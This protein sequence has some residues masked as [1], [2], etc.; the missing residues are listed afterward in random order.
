MPFKIR[1]VLYLNKDSNFDW[2]V[3]FGSMG[4]F[5]S[6]TVGAGFASGNEVMQFIGSWGVKGAI[7]AS[8]AGFIV[9]AIYT[10]CFYKVVRR[11]SLKRHQIFM[12]F[13]VEKY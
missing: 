3:I 6:Y 12:S 4:A 2:K 1:E 9:A 7:I 8:L 5:I 10:V 13:L 11:F